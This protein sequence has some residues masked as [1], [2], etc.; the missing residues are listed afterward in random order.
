MKTLGT[1]M[2]SLEDSPLGEMT[3]TV[4]LDMVAVVLC[5][6]LVSRKVDVLE[7]RKAQQ[8]GG[9]A[10]K[11]VARSTDPCRSVH[12]PRTPSDESSNVDFAD[13]NLVSMLPGL[14]LL[15]A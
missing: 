7:L 8:H 14:T 15:F 11:R 4:G 10:K 6:W 5:L 13:V 1:A 2:V 3:V 9:L 12:L